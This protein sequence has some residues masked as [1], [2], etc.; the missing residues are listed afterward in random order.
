MRVSPRPLGPEAAN[1]SAPGGGGEPPGA[2]N[3]LSVEPDNYDTLYHMVVVMRAERWGL[4]DAAAGYLAAVLLSTIAAVAWLGASAGDPLGFGALA[5]GQ[6]GLWAGLFATTLLASRF[7]G[8]GTLAQDF[9][10]RLRRRDA[11]V[12]LPIGVATQLVAVPIVYAGITLFTGPLDVGR[13]AQELFHRGGSAGVGFLL[14][15]VVVVAPFIEELFFR[16]LLMRSLANR[17]GGRWSV[18]L[19]SVLFGSTHFQ[20]VQLAGLTVAGLVFSVLAHRSGR[21]G[22]AIWAHVGFN[23]AAAVAVLAG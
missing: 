22:P 9:G 8:S 7:K 21:L 17:F 23:L 5:F 11:F 12:G 16:G 20:L 14:A 15:G 6:I 13:P 19:S 10:L 4:G 2:K 1:Q 3:A 18:V